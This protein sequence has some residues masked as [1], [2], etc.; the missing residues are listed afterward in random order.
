M[1]R[2]RRRVVFNETDNPHPLF[3]SV[4]VDKANTAKPFHGSIYNVR[5]PPE[6]GKHISGRQHKTP[7][8]VNL[9]TRVEIE[10]EQPR[11]V[12][13]PQVFHFAGLPKRSRYFGV[14]ARHLVIT[15]NRPL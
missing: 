12:V 13:I 15:P 1:F 5:G 10:I 4:P 11:P 8:A 7:K 3:V 6:I 14:V 2:V 9:R